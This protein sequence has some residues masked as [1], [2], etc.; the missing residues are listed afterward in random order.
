MAV[1]RD[2]DNDEK[3]TLAAITELESMLSGALPGVTF[4]VGP[5]YDPD[6]L[7]LTAIL[8]TADYDELID[9]VNDVVTDKL[10][11]FWADGIDVFVLSSLTPERQL[12]WNRKVR[13]ESWPNKAPSA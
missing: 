9:S 11:E 5:G 1:A 3:R 2:V 6:G 13:A 7:Y 8:E 12:A 10:L 4:S